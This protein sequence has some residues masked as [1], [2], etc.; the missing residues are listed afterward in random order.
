MSA[1]DYYVTPGSTAE[2]I[3]AAMEQGDLV[4]ICTPNSSGIDSHLV[5][6]HC[7]AV[8]GY[9]PS[10]SM[11]FEVFNPWGMDTYNETGGQTYGLFVAGGGFLEENF[12]IWGLTSTASPGS[13]PREAI[14]AAGAAGSAASRDSDEV[15]TL[16][17][18]T[19]ATGQ[20]RTGAN[21]VIQ[22]RSVDAS[23]RH[24]IAIGTVPTSGPGHS[25]SIDR[26]L[27]NR[28]LALWSLM[29]EDLES[30]IS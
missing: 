13:G 15:A 30:L 6:G 12:G 11:P 20:A 27:S 21:A 16:L 2:D 25:R 23:T 3:A 1:N 8:V 18:A 29:E 24:Q 5:G 9:D 26:D 10:S 28:D 17:A 4:C 14:L 22:T 7:Y 19:G